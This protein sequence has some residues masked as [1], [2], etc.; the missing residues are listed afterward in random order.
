MVLNP[1]KLKDGYRTIMN[2]ENLPNFHI[3][4]LNIVFNNLENIKLVKLSSCILNIF[5]RKNWG[6]NNLISTEEKL[7]RIIK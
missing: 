2:F 4:L 3:N 1:N 5:I 6:L 7:V